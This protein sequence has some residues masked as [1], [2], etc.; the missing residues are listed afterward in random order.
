MKTKHSSSLTAVP[1]IVVENLHF[2]IPSELSFYSW[3]GAA[4]HRIVAGIAQCLLLIGYL[5]G[6]PPF[7]RIQQKAL[8]K[9][10]IQQK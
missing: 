10:A 4:V 9:R 2:A 8:Y 7:Q 6:N 3:R 5:L 1:V